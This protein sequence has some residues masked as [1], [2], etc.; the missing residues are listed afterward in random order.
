[1]TLVD[2]RAA[3]PLNARVFESDPLGWYVE[4]EDCTAGLCQVET[5]EGR[6]WDP[7]C[8]QGNVIK[9]M[10]AR[11]LKAWGTDKV[12]RS[13][14]AIW[15]LGEHDFLEQ[16]PPFRPENI[17]CNP[18]SFRE[19]G[20]EAFLRKAVAIAS[21]TV[22]IYANARF[23]FGGARARGLFHELPPTKIWY[24]TPRPSCPPGDYIVAGGEPKGGKGDY[25]WLVYR[26][27]QPREPDGWI[28][29][30]GK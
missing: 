17:V 3:K 23:L 24:I 4:P 15:F 1:M 9:A 27:G 21:S 16:D 30:P 25:V 6:T 18:P 29:R 14:R 5:F 7:A 22:A 19:V 26:K 12:D 2:F 10:R 28:V 20:T 8:G 13:D 11:R